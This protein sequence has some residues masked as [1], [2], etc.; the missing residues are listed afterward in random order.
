MI[1]KIKMDHLYLA[2]H[3]IKGMKWGVRRFQ[4]ED[5]SLTSAGQKRYGVGGSHM[6]GAS[7]GGLTNARSQSM[8]RYVKRNGINGRPD[9]KAPTY[10][11]TPY[12]LTRRP[13]SKSADQKQD[14]QSEKK[15]V[16]SDKAKRNLKIAAG[17]A[18][19]AVVAYGAYK[20]GKNYVNAKKIDSLY[21]DFNTHGIIKR[22]GE[23]SKASAKEA[24]DRAVR[25]AR[26]NNSKIANAKDSDFSNGN[27]DRWRRS[28]ENAIAN[29]DYANIS[30]RTAAAR[31]KQGEAG[32]RRAMD[33]IEQIMDNESRTD[34][35]IR[36]YFQR[37]ILAGK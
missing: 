25:V 8:E 29:R 27:V 20:V 21:L 15:Q 14:G 9:P 17:V 7:T 2:H 31:I 28:V 33:A 3:G 1:G 30:A 4:N 37:S 35:R 10:K 6:R 16:L 13:V 22:E 24:F 5:G 26:E 36:E 23:F 32:Q 12:K 11:P 19:T 18:A 34:E